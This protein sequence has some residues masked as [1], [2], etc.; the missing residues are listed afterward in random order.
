MGV[1]TRTAFSPTLLA[2]HRRQ[3]GYSQPQLAEAAGFNLG[4]LRALEQG[5]VADPG[6]ATLAQ[7]AEALEITTDDLLAE[8]VA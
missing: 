5:R 4:T 3:R 6:I 7:L 2:S 8:P 1:P